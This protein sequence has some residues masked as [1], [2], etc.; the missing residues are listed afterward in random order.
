MFI[1]I[2]NRKRGIC[3]SKNFLLFF[4]FLDG[5]IVPIGYKNTGFINYP[6]T[7]LSKWCNKESNANLNGWGC[8]QL[9][10]T[11]SEYFKKVVRMKF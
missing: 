5:E 9:A 1:L 6:L 7:D 4:Q 10:A 2:Y 3:F 8:A 11:D